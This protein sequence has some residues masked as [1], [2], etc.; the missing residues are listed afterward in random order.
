[1]TATPVK[2]RFAPSPTGR[3]HLGNLRTAL[4]NCLLARHHG[5]EF[6]LR[7]EDSDLARN[8]ADGVANLQAD[9]RWLGLEWDEGPGGG[10]PASEWQQSAR[11]AIHHQAV[12]QLLDNGLAYPCFCSAERL[13]SLRAEQKKAGLPPRYDGHCAGIPAGVAAARLAAGESASIRLL[14]PGAGTI[15]FDDLLR[16]RQTFSAEALSDPVIRRA[17]GSAAF[18]LANAVDDAQIGITHVIRG[19]DHLSNTPRQIVLLES[20]GLEAPGYGH[21]GLVV[22]TDGTPLSKRTGAAGVDELAR[23]GYRPEAVINYLA[24]LGG[25]ISTDELHGLDALAERFTVQGLTRGPARFDRTQLDH[26]QTKAMAHL[27]AD[28]LGDAAAAAGVPADL[29]ASFTA[30]VHPNL[31]T[32]A[33]VDDWARRLCDS[34]AEVLD[35]AATPAGDLAVI[36]EVSPAF[37]LAA[38][39]ALDACST[40]DWA[41]VRPALEAAT[42]T[43]GG[44]LMKPLRLALTGL[45]YGPTIGEI[46][47]F[48]PAATRR[49]RLARAAEL[50]TTGVSPDA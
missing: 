36:I 13:Q 30:L 21:V 45:G 4:F 24:R 50:A 7:V 41:T 20:L 31:K 49:A 16:G 19:E 15:G 10:Q 42:G 48:M 5:G 3:L 32:L 44:R 47:E 40:S 2:T 37:F 27:S 17:D 18:L 9:L 6:L 35:P 14:M 26:W 33:D 29:Q 22:N 25:S 38:R 1:M 11:G 43:R 46:I 23:Q 34:A 39:D 12:D 28:E 8:Q